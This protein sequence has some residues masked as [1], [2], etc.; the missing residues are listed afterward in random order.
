MSQVFDEKE[1][2]R[3]F[4]GMKTTDE[5]LNQVSFLNQV[6]PISRFVREKGFTRTLEVGL[7]VG[8]SACGIIVGSG[9]RHVA[10][11]PHQKKIFGYFGLENL[12]D[13]GFGQNI[14][15]YEVSSCVILPKLWRD[16][17]RFEF[18]YIDGDHKFDSVLTD[19]YLADLLLEIGGYVLLDDTWMPSVVRAVETILSQRKG[20]YVLEKAL[21]PRSVLLKKLSVSR[22]KA[23]KAGIF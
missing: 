4:R 17:R 5:T 21:S 14:E 9:A 3:I 7:A 18:I 15:F 22:G 19:F 6:I 23:A 11:D 10:M 12:A 20:E 2:E 8:G 16:S 1:I 13:N